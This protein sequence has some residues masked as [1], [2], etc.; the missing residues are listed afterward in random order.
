[1]KVLVKDISSE[2]SNFEGTI[3]SNALDL[4]CEYWQLDSDAWVSVDA[5]RAGDY[6][7]LAI[8][9]EADVLLTCTRCL[10]QV[11]S[12]RNWKFFHHI[13]IVSELQE[14]N[15]TQLV[16]EEIILSIG[17]KNLCREDCQGICP[18]CGGNRNLG[19]CKCK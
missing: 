10:E 3:P 7:D 1:M 5:Y 13:K 12:H 2:R 9:V 15:I 4:D 6:V 18:V 16:R 8:Y 17:M 19:E 14:L 11:R